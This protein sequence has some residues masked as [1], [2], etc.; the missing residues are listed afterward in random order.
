M[1]SN[2]C[3]ANKKGAHAAT[4]FLSND[5][6]ST[7]SFLLYLG[8]F[9]AYVKLCLNWPECSKVAHLG[10]FSHKTYSLQFVPIN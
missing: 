5:A 4:F 6:Y 8:S 1:Q 2:F 3:I 9:Y 10:S 7:V